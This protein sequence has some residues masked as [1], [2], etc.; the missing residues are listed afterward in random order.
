[1]GWENGFDRAAFERILA[2]EAAEITASPLIAEYFH[3]P[4]GADGAGVIRADLVPD[5]EWYP[6]PYF[7]RI[8]LALGFD[9]SLVSF[10]ALPNKAG[11]NN[12]ICLCRGADIRRDFDP[13]DR[14][15]IQ[16]ANAAITS[17]LD[18]PLARFD[19]PCPTRL[20]P[21][22]RQ[23]LTCLLEG[24]SDKQVAVRLRISPHTV[25]QYVKTIFTRFGVTTRAELLARWIKRGWG[26]GGW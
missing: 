3:R 2:E 15:R 26:R 1:M 7:E 17:L 14:V 25:N 20:P 18:G 9:H 19:E 13:R 23:V 24:D 8:Q 6:T 16:E 5:G 4:T 12:G 10:L 21:R 22:V 11:A